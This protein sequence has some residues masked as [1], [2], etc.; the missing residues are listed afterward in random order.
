MSHINLLPWREER[1]KARKQQFLTSLGATAFCAMLCVGLVHMY[2]E[3][4]IENQN[5]RN[6]FLEQ[7]IASLDDKIAKIKE[8]EKEK[9]SLIARMRAI[10]TLQ[11][12]RPL[13]VHLFDEL[14]RSLPEG[15]FLNSIEQ[16]G[17]QL[18]LNG[19][20][21]SNARVSNFMR[22]LEAS[23]W[24]TNARLEVIESRDKQRDRSNS[25]TLHINQIV[26][27]PEEEFA[28]VTQS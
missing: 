13:V 25:F 10:E 6:T 22:N 1:R 12:S 7:E 21:Q 14:V 16:R 3:K 17:E 18:T 27:Q 24:L 28:E 2:F 20:A 26:T 23:E 15:I 4:L 9:S 5:N 11:T 8:L 19:T